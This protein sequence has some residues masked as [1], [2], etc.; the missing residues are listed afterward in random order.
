[1]LSYIVTFGLVVALGL[2][3]DKFARRGEDSL[4][5][6]GL[7][8]GDRAVCGTEL[9]ACHEKCIEKAFICDTINDCSGGFDEQNCPAN[10]TGVNVYKCGNGKCIPKN[11]QC[12]TQDDCGDGTDEANC[13]GTCAPG[14]QKCQNGHCVIDG[15]MCDGKNNCGDGSD[16][17]QCTGLSCNSFQ[18]TCANGTCIPKSYKCDFDND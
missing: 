5:G 3:I 7:I 4:V 15:W 8:R 10:C 13:G 12:D 17:R 16:E 14:Y 6:D 1:M 9:F 18:F 2:G 11:Y